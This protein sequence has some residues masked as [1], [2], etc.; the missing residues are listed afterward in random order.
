MSTEKAERA[1]S[2]IV[3]HFRLFRL[4]VTEIAYVSVFAGKPVTGFAQMAIGEV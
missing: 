1:E 2:L 4:H 3:D